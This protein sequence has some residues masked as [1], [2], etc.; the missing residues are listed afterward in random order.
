MIHHIIRFLNAVSEV[1]R[2]AYA[3]RRAMQRKYRSISE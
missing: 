2:D 1:V 3:M